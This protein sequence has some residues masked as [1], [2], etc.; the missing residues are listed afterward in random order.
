MPS[1]CREPLCPGVA[2]YRGY[3][4]EHT[5]KKERRGTYGYHL[6]RSKKWRRT[7]ARVLLDRPLCDECRAVAT[8]VHHR[9]DLEEGGAPFDM[10]NLQALCHSCHSRITRLER[11]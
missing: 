8:D 11:V 4:P 10:D 9:V 1:T 3:C 5:R 6:Y 2:T 7:R